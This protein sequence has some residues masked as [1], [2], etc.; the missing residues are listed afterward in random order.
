[1][2]K[3]TKGKLFKQCYKKLDPNIKKM[4]RESISFKAAMENKL[5]EIL[6]VE[7]GDIWRY[8]EFTK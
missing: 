2:L 8:D 1:M 3:N 5:K 6:E 4:N 7:Q